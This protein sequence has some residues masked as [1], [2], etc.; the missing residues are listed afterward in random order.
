[1]A[2]VQDSHPEAC[3]FQAVGSLGIPVQERYSSRTGI[4]ALERAA[5]RVDNTGLGGPAA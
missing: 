3:Q 1:M 4:E 2:A 5:A